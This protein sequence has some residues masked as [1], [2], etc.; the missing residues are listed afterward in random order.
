MQNRSPVA[1]FF[2]SMFTCGIYG[3]VWTVKTKTEINELT[4][5]QIPTLWLC[6][7]PFVSF[8]WLWKYAQGVEQVTDGATSAGVAYLM[9]MLLGPIGQAILQSSYNNVTAELDGPMRITIE[10]AGA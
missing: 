5:A 2:L 7:I 8:W 3:I 9:L 10:G 6:L 4:D 1:V